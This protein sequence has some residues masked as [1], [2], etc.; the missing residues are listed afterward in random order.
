M[1]FG[2]GANLGQVSRTLQTI[3]LRPLGCAAPTG[4]CVFRCVYT[5]LR[6]ALLVLRPYGACVIPCPRLVY[7]STASTIQPPSHALR[8]YKKKQSRSPAF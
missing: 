8:S 6:A 4:L 2:E 1:R 3:P 5:A 7:S